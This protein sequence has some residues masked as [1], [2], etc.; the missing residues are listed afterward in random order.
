MAPE[1]M[2]IATA[3]TPLFLYQAGEPLVC[4][5]KHH[6][7]ASSDPIYFDLLAAKICHTTYCLLRLWRTSYVL[8]PLR[9]LLKGSLLS[10]EFSVLYCSRHNHW[11]LE[12][13]AHALNRMQKCW[14]TLSSQ[15]DLV[16]LGGKQKTDKFMTFLICNY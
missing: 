1:L 14:Q 8:Q 12:K 9:L 10:V 11:S 2:C 4:I 15:D 3:Q 6:L 7:D 5:S 13:G 16:I